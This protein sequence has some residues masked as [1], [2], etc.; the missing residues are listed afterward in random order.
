[1]GIEMSLSDLGQSQHVTD[2][3]IAEVFGELTQKDPNA[4]TTPIPGAD[5]QGGEDQGQ[6]NGDQGTQDPQ[7]Q[8]GDDDDDDE[9]RS[10]RQSAE[11]Q[12]AATPEEREAARERDRNR[13]QNQRQRLKAKTEALERQLANQ[14]ATNQELAQ[15]IHA[16]ENTNQSSQLAQFRNAENQASQAIQGLKDI[17]ADATAKGD[18]V[19]AAEANEAMARVIREQERL[20]NARQLFEQQLTAPRQRQTAA[21]NQSM[22]PET[23]SQA[24]AFLRKHPWYKGPKSNDR[25]SKVMAMLD[26]EMFDEGWNPASPTYWSELES[27][28]KQYIG[29][30]FNGSTDQEGNQMTTNNNGQ[31]HN[32]GQGQRRPKSPIA[33]GGNI[34]SN[35]ARNQRADFNIGRDRVQALKDSGIWD[36]PE[37][38]KRVIAQWQ[39]QDAGQ[40]E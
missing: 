6:G 29:H 8:G 17:I 34:N 16:L 12:A 21:P 2:E 40:A 32:A 23:L 20:T 14:L 7:S 4:E 3:E 10:T 11:E 26:K 19:R 35:G 37:A 33:G 1:M 36:N 31:A 18:G 38:R 13:R 24:Q 9:D 39:K 5:D 28:A 22:D 15:R 25:D 30:R 27:R